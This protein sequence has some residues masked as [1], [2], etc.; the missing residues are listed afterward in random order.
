[1]IIQHVMP[2]NILV[3][4]DDL[5]IAEALVDNLEIEGHTVRHATD[6]DVALVMIMNDT[7]DLILLDVMLPKKNGF[8][9]LREVRKKKINAP[10][11]MLTAK[12][13][14]FDK[15]LGLDLGADD[16]VVKPFSLNELLS[17]IG[18]QLRRYRKFHGAG[19]RIEFDSVV[20][21][22]SK[23][24]IWVDGQEQH[25]TATE[26]DI[27]RF[28][29]ER[30]GRVLSRDQILDGVWGHGYFGTARTVDNFIRNLRLK[31]EKDPTQPGYIKTVRGAGYVF[32]RSLS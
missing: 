18:A 12:S 15:C 21:D 24:R 9:V 11:I 28:L 16:Y 4:E 26:L 3:V 22:F 5:S 29:V 27:L 17:R 13:E 20:V 1:M 6:G 2:A 8:E 23:R 30:E 32:Q 19:D 7:P 25:V 10:V 14:E 31:I